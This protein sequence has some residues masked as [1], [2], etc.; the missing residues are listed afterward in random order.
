MNPPSAH[1]LPNVPLRL[2]K[3][4]LETNIYVA[5]MELSSHRKKLL[6]H[7]FLAAQPIHPKI[8]IIDHGG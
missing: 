5:M 2:N 1:V 7:C 4:R 6:R 8:T 3:I